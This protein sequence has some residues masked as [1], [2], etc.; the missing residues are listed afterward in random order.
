MELME[1]KDNTKSTILTFLVIIPHRF[2]I[3]SLLIPKTCY[4]ILS[5]NHRGE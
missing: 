2:L 3:Y 1:S 5:T 4:M